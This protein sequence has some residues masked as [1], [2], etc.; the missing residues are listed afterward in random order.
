MGSSANNSGAFSD[1]HRAL[2]YGT[3]W[4]RPDN[5]FIVYELLG[6]IDRKLE[7]IYGY[8]DRIA[9]GR[10]CL[11]NIAAAGVFSS[12]RSVREYADEIWHIGPV[13]HDGAGTLLNE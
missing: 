5:Y 4:S 7:A 10:K 6:Y 11:L 9:F 2:L 8:R 12:D 1:L 13:E 3:S